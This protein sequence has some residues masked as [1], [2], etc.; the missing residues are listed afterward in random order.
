M[1]CLSDQSILGMIIIRLTWII[2]NSIIPKIGSIRFQSIAMSDRREKIDSLLAEVERESYARGWRDAIAALQEKAPE[3]AP[4]D[5]N[6]DKRGNG[7]S[8]DPGAHQR[9]RGRPE[10]AISLVKNEIFGD[11]G[12]RGVDIV[13]SLEKKRTP[14]VDR[15]VRSALRRLKGSKTVWQRNGKWYPRLKER[16]DAE[17]EIGEVAGTPPH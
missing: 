6:A 10:K 16:P 9:Q 4:S 12:L 5:P 13:R 17:N 8:A 2:E 3:M 7:A 15:T 14:V 11:P 1:A